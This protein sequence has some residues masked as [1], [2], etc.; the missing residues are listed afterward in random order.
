MAQR[1]EALLENPPP[2]YDD[3]DPVITFHIHHG[4]QFRNM[5]ATYEGGRLSIFDYV[6]INF[7]SIDF[8]DR[9]C[10][11]LGYMGLKR[12]VWLDSMTFKQLMNGDDIVKL[13]LD[14][15]ADR[16]V[17]I[18]VE[19]MSD[20]IDSQVGSSHLNE[21]E[22]GSDFT[23]SDYDMET[24]DEGGLEDDTAFEKHVDRG[25]E[26]DGIDEGNQSRGQYNDEGIGSDGEP[27]LLLSEDDFESE[28]GSDSENDEP[29]YPVFSEID[30]D[31]PKFSLGMIFSTKKEFR[32]AINSHAVR[33]RRSL[34]ITKNDERRIY[35]KCMG[36]KCD[37]KIH[38]LKL[39][40]ESTFQIRLYNSVHKC[41]GS[42]SVKNVKSGWLSKKFESCFRTDP[43]R[44]IKGFREDAVMAIRC[45]ISRFQ[46]YRTKMKALKTIEGN[47]E[48]QYAKLWDYAAELRRTN[49][50]STVVMNLADDDSGKFGRFYVCFQ[51]SKLGFQSGCRPLIGVDGCHLKGPHGGV[52]LAAIGI[53]PNNNAY[54]LAIAVVFRENKDNWEWFLM[55]LKSDLNIV[56]DHEF[57]FIS[58]KQKGLIPAFESIFPA[59]DN[60]FC[61]RHF[62]G[63]MKRAE[64]K[65]LAYKRL[66]WKAAMSTTVPD[67]ES[68]MKEI[69]RL[70][71]N[72]LKWLSDKSPN[73]WS[74]SHF[75]PYPKCDIL[76]NNLCESFNSNILDAR[77]KPILVMLEMIREWMMTRLQ[78]N[79]DRAK[80]KWHSK[81][82]P[83]IRTIMAKNIELAADCV[84]IKSNEFHYEVGTWLGS[85]K[86][87]V[88]LGK[89]TRSC[90]KWDLSD[91]PCQHAMSAVCSQVK[92]PEDYVHE[93]YWVD[94]YHKVYEHAIYPING[95]SL[96]KE[97]GLPGPKPPNEGRVAG[98][99]P[100]ARRMEP[101]EPARKQKKKAP[102][103]GTRLKRQQST[104]RCRVCGEKGHNSKAHRKQSTGVPNE[105][106]GLGDSIYEGQTSGAA[107]DPLHEEQ[108]S[109]HDQGDQGDQG[110]SI[111]EDIDMADA[112]ISQPQSDPPMSQPQTDPS[113]SQLQTN[114]STKIPVRKRAK[115]KKSTKV[116][117]MVPPNPSLYPRRSP[118][119]PRPPVETPTIQKPLT[120]ILKNS[121]PPAVGP[122]NKL[123]K[124]VNEK[125]PFR[126]PGLASAAPSRH[127]KRPASD[128]SQTSRQSKLATS[129]ASS[130][131]DSPSLPESRPSKGV[132]IR[133]PVPFAP[134]HPRVAVSMMTKRYSEEHTH[135]IPPVLM[136]NEKRYFTIRNL[137]SAMEATVSK[138]RERMQQSEKKD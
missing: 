89:H 16:V 113:L 12:Y 84:P 136:K 129:V 104:I 59:C 121:R 65:G 118:A 14:H 57:T 34:K 47:H 58:D 101:G 49:P 63:N 52:L 80:Q 48:N 105:E 42:Y 21:S 78:V 7:V 39:G 19:A 38:A 26:W 93:Y 137:N 83:K 51:A 37:W 29:K 135:N 106:G 9:L 122:V 88:D 108:R 35:A 134:N 64:F 75:N 85:S 6:D 138:L 68:T 111:N 102:W 46:A 99:P 91:I 114:Q 11:K 4:G 97:T 71:K 77:E 115:S 5:T 3:V 107:N 76:L 100:S 13:C 61:V 23:D 8:V 131:S 44:N 62:H 74:R 124:S 18:Y 28:R 22:Q 10:E 117:S 86:Y 41:Y 90:R 27:D 112:P 120:G 95:S 103:H 25:V 60:R 40:T 123:R 30:S 45:N 116:N 54:P 73:H 2:E 43:K 53:D 119:T 31:N 56:R 126:P 1:P 92:D 15:Y 130:S 33:T 109:A 125:P 55:L 132:N 32:L 87:T 94:T 66:L 24:G 67:F 79:R 69:G 72:A 127:R 96:W 70:D 98:R 110:E 82:C 17:D 128:S 50:G 81:V 133:E 36:H 20:L